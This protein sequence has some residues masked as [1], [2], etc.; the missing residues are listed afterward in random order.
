MKNLLSPGLE[1]A[2]AQSN[3]LE[4]EYNEDAVLTLEISY[5]FQES[6]RS[7][8]IYAVADGMGGHLHGEVA[9]KVAVN[10]VAATLLEHVFLPHLEPSGLQPPNSLTAIFREALIAAH[11]EVLQKANGGG[12]TLTCCLVF[13]NTLTIAHVGDSRAYSITPDGE[14]RLHTRDHSLVKRLVELGQISEREAQNHPQRNV[15]YRALGQTDPNEAD[16]FSLPL[17]SAG[18]LLLCSDGLW[19]VVPEEKIAQTIYAY[20]RLQ[21]ACHQ[22]VQLA[23][24]GGGPDNISVI[25]VKFG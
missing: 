3:G 25:L 19:S 14:M 10:R 11:Q 23:N 20:P 24:E 21:E 5:A 7:M 4:R 2:F 18:Y 12:T 16:I 22:L 8:G 9:S 17:P 6:A 13:G 15:L 1:S